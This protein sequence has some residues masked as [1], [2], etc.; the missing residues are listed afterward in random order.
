V[1]PVV[2]V[3][4]A[5]CAV[6]TARTSAVNVALVAVAGTVTELGTATELLLLAS[7]TLM[8]PEGAE[9][10]RLTVHE[11]DNPPVIEVLPHESVLIVGATD[12]PVPLRGTAAV[13]A[14][15]EIVNWPVTEVAVVGAY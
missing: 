14:V 5:A 4:E 12:V 6:V 7:T 1:D 11:S 2:A 13:G 8:P 3:S 15:L 10:V 9:P